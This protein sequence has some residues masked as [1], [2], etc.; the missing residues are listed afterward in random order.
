MGLSHRNNLLQQEHQLITSLFY[1]HGYM[2]L[3]KIY[4]GLCSSMSVYTCITYTI[5]IVRHRIIYMHVI[6][7]VRHSFIYIIVTIRYSTEI[8]KAR[9]DK[10]EDQPDEY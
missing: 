1:H 4:N 5:I 6:M 8:Q 7:I 2:C 3:A 9:N 10:F